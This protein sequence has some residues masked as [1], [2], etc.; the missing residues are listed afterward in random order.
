M[1]TKEKIEYK[2]DYLVE[3]FL[4]LLDK[5]IYEAKDML[6]ERFEYICSQSSDSAKFMYENNVMAGYDGANI[7]SAL[8]H[9]TLAV[10]QIGLA[11]TLQILIDENQTTEKGMA[12]AKRIEQLFKDRCAEFKE[13]YKL[14]FGVYYTPAE[15]LCYTALKK[16][17][18]KYGIIPKVSDKE[19]FTNSIHIPV[20]EQV[21]PFEKIDL[22]SQ[23]TGYSSAGCITYVELDAGMK[24]NISAL[25]TL[26]N[27]AMDKDIPY[28]AINIPVD[29][30]N[31]CGY[32]GEF[33]DICPE[34]GG[35][36][37]SHLRRV[38]GYL[39]GSYK[40]SFNLGK[41]AET[42]DRFRHSQLRRY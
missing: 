8:I 37:V 39:T 27:Y 25:E 34:C 40:D 3:A 23:L 6:I 33:N 35:R 12:L 29:N 26:V 24:N 19:Y 41:Q 42:E 14:N 31:D 28:F 36:N 30:C 22:E 9:G 15:G 7:R 18:K 5:K 2:E 13:K 16:F 17:R 1:E 21:T 38:T 4:K 32:S 11:E 20:Y 10:G